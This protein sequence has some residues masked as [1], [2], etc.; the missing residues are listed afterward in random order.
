MPSAPW[1]HTDHWFTSRSAV[2]E[3]AHSHIDPRSLSH[4]IVWQPRQ[5]DVPAA[6]TPFASVAVLGPDEDANSRALELLA[7]Q[8]HSRELVR[9]SLCAHLAAPAPGTD[10]DVA[11]EVSADLAELAKQIAE[12]TD[13]VTL[14][15]FT[16]GVLE[17][18]NR[19][20]LPQSSL[21]GLANVIAAEQPQ[22][23]GGLVDLEITA[24][25]K[26]WLPVVAEQLNTS[27]KSVLVLRDGKILAPELLPLDGASGEPRVRPR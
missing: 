10:L 22:I 21:W 15:V 2:A 24:H 25:P 16:H 1:H 26:Q 19:S 20:V 5:T 3:R 4:R 27:S 12:R 9:S 18:A 8:G 17:S 13:P 23:W 11:V 7:D 14:W 6:P